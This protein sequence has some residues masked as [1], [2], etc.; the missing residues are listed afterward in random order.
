LDFLLVFLLRLRKY[1]VPMY[2]ELLVLFDMGCLDLFLPLLMAEAELL[3]L[4][5]VFLFLKL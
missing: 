3:I 5:V 1:T 2:I 4:H